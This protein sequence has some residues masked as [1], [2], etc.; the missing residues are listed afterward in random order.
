[1]AM[2]QTKTEKLCTDLKKL[3]ARAERH[4]ENLREGGETAEIAVQQLISTV[5][6]LWD[7]FDA[8]YCGGVVEALGDIETSLEDDIAD[9]CSD[10]AIHATSV[11]MEISAVHELVEEL[12]TKVV[13]KLTGILSYLE[14][15]DDTQEGVDAKA[16]AWDILDY[17]SNGDT[18]RYKDLFAKA[19]TK[20]NDDEVVS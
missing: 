5:T 13:A 18:D 4:A 16:N 11:R 19:K 15:R 10:M 1:M 7:S 17:I 20:E 6:E 14:G 8:D 9:R 12:Q 2:P 3:T